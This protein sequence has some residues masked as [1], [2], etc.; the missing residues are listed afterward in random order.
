MAAFG[1]LD[2]WYFLAPGAAAGRRLSAA[3]ANGV[4]VESLGGPDGL[5]KVSQ[6]GRFKRAYA[7]RGEEYIPYLAPHDAF[8]YLPTEAGRLSLNRTENLDRYRITR[9]TLLQTCSG[10][11]LGP[12]VIADSY[13]ARYATS[14][15][16]VRI[17]CGDGRIR[18]WIAAW[19]RSRTG[20]EL[21]R[22]DKSGSVIDHI[23]VG[24]VSAQEIPMLDDGTVD[25]AAHLIGEQFRLVEEARTELAEMLREY[26]ARL[27]CEARHAPPKGGWTVPASGINN[28]LDAAF[29]DPWVASVRQSLLD[30][31]GVLA[32]D[33]AHASI[34]ERYKRIYVGAEHGTPFLSGSNVLQY[35]SPH[36]QYM[37]ERAVRDSERHKVR[38]GM[39]VYQVDGR[40]E[41]ALGV[42]SL[43]TR[44]RD[45][46]MATQHIGRLQ[47]R[48]GVDPGWLWL[49]SRT[50]QALAQI[51]ALASGSVVDALYESD[52]EKV[53]L[54]PDKGVDGPAVVASWAKFAQARGAEAEA[55]ALVD[56]RLA[57]VSG[58]SDVPEDAIIRITGG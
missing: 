57:E 6:P 56:A 36:Q 40:A 54:P 13:L 14:H 10:R 32:G 49:A 7:G 38:E 51:K 41:K 5:A 52:M 58:V 55:I 35:A 11:N 18:N 37:S 27:P 44:D 24:H 28:R 53:V 22:R 31:G 48:P 17:E 46:W 9:G 30:A 15:D 47:P 23:S 19:L 4:Q 34:P 39:C 12:N 20:Q 42:P 1:R 29:H 3:K 26:E 50:W 43:V 33:V 16:L 8:L 25:E 21:L 2:A 45:G